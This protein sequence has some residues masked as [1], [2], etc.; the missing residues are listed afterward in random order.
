[1]RKICYFDT[2]ALAKW[3]IN[4]SGSDEVENFIRT[5]GPIAISSVTKIEFK[6]LLARRRRA[7]EIDPETEMKILS[8]F[9]EDLLFGFIINYS[10]TDEICDEA[11][12]II[13]HLPQVALRTLDSLHLA[14][15]RLNSINLLATADRLMEK[16]GDL[17]G[18]ETVGF[19]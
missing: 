19:G 3:Y 8:L 2:S 7:S 14:V 10:L 13:D 5:H 12:N 16:A 17:L 4:E 11:C 6:S 1:M 18:I 9:K 15:C